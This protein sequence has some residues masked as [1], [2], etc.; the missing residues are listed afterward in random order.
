LSAIAPFT[1]R[2][3]LVTGKGGVGRSTTAAALGHAF[4]SAGEAVLLLEIGGV[5]DDASALA[6]AFGRVRLPTK[7]ERIDTV[8]RPERGA[9]FGALL[10]A[11]TGHERF[12]RRVLPG[13]PLVAA[14]L[15]NDALQR[16]LNAAPSFQ[17]MGIFYHLLTILRETENQRFRWDRVIIDMPATGHTLALTEL[18]AQLLR[19]LPN[20]FIGEEL[21]AG[22]TLLE[23]RTQTGAVVVT[24][25]ERLPITESRELAQGLAKSGV[26]LCA[27]V[28]NKMPATDFSKEERDVLD[29][30]LAHSP[31][32]FGRGDYLR[33]ADAKGLARE[34]DG[35]GAPLVLLPELAL[36]GPALPPALIPYL[37]KGPS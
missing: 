4:A 9:I 10:L 11:N 30:W 2:I 36:S 5:G 19:L 21:R 8:T 33:S 26:G 22:R 14:A 32:L 35:D 12:L 7:P 34:L 13:G 3:L 6:R 28:V 37:T 15:R 1:P 24:L 27:Y 23:D 29:T 25:P 31:P 17:E 20:G 16:L 18:P